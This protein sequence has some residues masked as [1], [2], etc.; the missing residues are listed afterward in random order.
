MNTLIRAKKGE[1]LSR[2]NIAKVHELLSGESPITK[3]EACGILN[4]RYNTT[5]LKKII[6][7]YLEL[8][9]YRENRKSQLKGKGA[10]KDEIKTVIVDYLDGDNI[11]TI[12][13]RMYRSPAF[14]RAILERVGVPKK[15]ADNDYEG[16]RTYMLPEE[17]VAEEFAVG[18]KVWYPRKNRFAEIRYEVTQKYQ[19]DRA[20]YVGYQNMAK[21]VNYE[22]KYGAKM[23]NLYVL[24]PVPQEAISK[25]YF[26]WLDGSRCGFYAS[27]LA[28][29]LGSL[30][31][32]EQYGV[33]INS[34]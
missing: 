2:D 30:K 23:Y 25:S 27:A 12:S 15:L 34:L 33:N 24:D 14:V 26:P 22:D 32:L 13:E 16:H 5:R 19:F 17:C 9:E 7:D 31:H 8:S 21:C 29:D 11:S 28:Y 6:D 10:T 18:E 1:N 3:K 4:I 20:G